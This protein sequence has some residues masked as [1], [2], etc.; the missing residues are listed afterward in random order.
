MPRGGG[1]GGTFSNPTVLN[2]NV[3]DALLA[4]GVISPA[5]A[6]A[7]AIDSNNAIKNQ[8]LEGYEFNMTG[9]LTNNWQINFNYSYTDGY[10]SEIGPEVKA[11]AETAIPFYLQFPDVMTNV[12]G[13][14]SGFM[15]VRFR[16]RI[17]TRPA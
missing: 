5:E 7:R 2:D 9:Q 16:G 3:M 6:D 10:D 1:F 4:A 13:G 14:A 15:T 8:R 12:E 17:R 11:W